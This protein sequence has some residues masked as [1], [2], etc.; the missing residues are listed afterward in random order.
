MLL[1][2]VRLT[3]SRKSWMRFNVCQTSLKA[4]DDL[5]MQ[6]TLFETKRREKSEPKNGIP[7]RHQQLDPLTDRDR[8]LRLILETMP[9]GLIIQQ[10]PGRI[11]FVNNRFA[12]ISGYRAGQLAGKP[13][14]EIVY[15]EDQKD[16]SLNAARAIAGKPTPTHFT[17]RVVTRDNKLK[18]L[19]VE[20]FHAPWHDSPSLIWYVYD[21]SQTKLSLMQ[22]DKHREMLCT[23]FDIVPI[24]TAIVTWREG[25]FI[26]AN[27]SFFENTG[28][29]KEDVIGHTVAETGFWPDPQERSRV[30]RIVDGNGV[31][32]T[33]PVKVKIRNGEIHDCIFSAQLVQFNDAPCTL[34]LFIDVSQDKSS[35]VGLTDKEST[36]SE[37]KREI[38]NLNAALKVLIDHQESEK[39]DQDHNLVISLKKTIFP[40]LDKIK[41][42]KIDIASRTYL[43][44]LELN[45]NDLISSLPNTAASQMQNLTFTETQVVDLIRQG[46]TSKEIAAMLNV[47]TAAISF[48]RHNLRKKMGLVKKKTTLRS[49]LQALN[50]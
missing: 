5:D 49:Y 9:A 40:Y 41:T 2:K 4:E 24:S 46:K 11:A 6:N 10:T 19:K 3:L 50:Q 31:V 20:M 44:M 22:S 18:N 27:P 26:E 1:Y 13:L 37:K 8:L 23:L 15:L 25:R 16:V 35:E 38:Q 14:N 30:M 43:S 28:Y 21:I 47:S 32:K 17:F 7:W 39:K 12:E 45:L 48:H 36:L 29:L 42:G 33:F 34:E